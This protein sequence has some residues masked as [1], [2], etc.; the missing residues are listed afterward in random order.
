MTDRDP[1]PDSAPESDDDTRS[2]IEQAVEA[3]Q[4]AV[5]N[6]EGANGDEPAPMTAPGLY[7]GNAGTG[8]VVKNQDRDAQ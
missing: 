1:H 3:R 7:S 5:E 2:D 8:G 4:D 6:G